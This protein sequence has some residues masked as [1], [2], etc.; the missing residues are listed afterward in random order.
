MKSQ[1]RSLIWKKRVASVP[2]LGQAL[3]RSYR[4]IKKS[5]AV[6]V[7]DAEITKESTAPKVQKAKP[8][9]RAKP[10]KVSANLPNVLLPVNVLSSTPCLDNN[11]I[12]SVPDFAQ[13]IE[14][15]IKK[16]ADQM[17]I[18]LFP[19]TRGNEVF[20]GLNENDALRFALFMSA[21]MNAP[22]HW[23][24]FEGALDR[25]KTRENLRQRSRLK[26]SLRGK[27]SF[28]VQI[29]ASLYFEH[30][31][32]LNSR[33]SDN[34][35]LRHVHG[36]N[37]AL[38]QTKGLHQI[39]DLLGAPPDEV[40]TTPVDVVFTWV[41]HDDPDWS[42]M[43]LKAK[44]QA[45]D[46]AAPTTEQP[47]DSDATSLARFTNRDELL[48]SIRS[49]ERY[50][51][52]VNRIFVFSNCA[53]P[54]WLEPSDRVVWVL[55]DDVVPKKYLPTFNSHAIE[56]SLHLIPDLS[57]NFLYF[58]D[59]F[60]IN[61][62]L[63]RSFFFASNDI[64]NANLE[65]Y[66]VVNG[67]PHPDDKDYLNAARN[68]VAL[69]RDH[70]NTVPTRLHK[71]TPY[72]LKK[73]ILQEIETRFPE[74]ISRTRAAQFRSISDVSLLSFLFHHYAF[75]TGRGTQIGYRTRLVKNAGKNV[76]Q[77]L[78]NLHNQSGVR[79]FCI[80]DGGE[81]YSDPTWNTVVPAFLK[82]RFSVPCAHERTPEQ[83]AKLAAQ[84]INDAA[85][86]VADDPQTET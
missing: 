10:V 20:I 42:E 53:A 15:A 57:E 80:N 62:A 40:A 5:D 47:Q 22:L 38:M 59:D 81:S 82:S 58:N 19:T 78:A 24:G 29:V 3:R 50:I 85:E 63:P 72:A 25:P 33:D 65:D 55:H 67:Y 52:W 54:L 32:M 83:I 16:I 73:S 36:Q 43:Y 1:S 51:P 77:T 86:I 48:Y 21:H 70:M 56:C 26:M 68:G 41:N 46:D 66:G 84:A 27:K 30:E 45:P 44:G 18:V 4:L 11:A 35:M 12:L 79:T 9:S 64:P 74:E 60:F 7:Q 8:A 2:V 75:A 61:E 49:I 28:H 14:N 34:R 71:H 17:P 39:A 69:L 13:A 23:D 6:V 76:S 31:G 37:M